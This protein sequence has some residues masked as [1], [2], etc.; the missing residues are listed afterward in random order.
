MAQAHS[1]D[2]HRPVSSESSAN[3]RRVFTAIQGSHT[4]FP[5]PPFIHPRGQA[6]T[7]RA[8]DRHVGSQTRFRIWQ[9]ARFMS[10]VGCKKCRGTPAN[11]NGTVQ[12]TEPC[13]DIRRSGFVL[14]YFFH[15]PGFYLVRF[16]IH[17]NCNNMAH[18]LPSNGPRRRRRQR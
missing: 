18:V 1:V 16:F 10:Q 13:S 5:R 8:K 7:G 6:G 12:P 9:C 14:F 2:T 15:S 11:T 4:H 3:L 17:G